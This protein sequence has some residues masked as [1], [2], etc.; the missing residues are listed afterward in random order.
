MKAAET[1]C[2]DMTKL[3]FLV[4]PMVIYFIHATICTLSTAAFQVNGLKQWKQLAG[5]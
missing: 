2:W 5:T 3:P 1:A 4:I